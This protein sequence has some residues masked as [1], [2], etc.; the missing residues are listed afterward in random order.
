ML[1]IMRVSKMALARETHLV[2]TI[3]V[4]DETINAGT[5]KT[6]K[7]LVVKD[8]EEIMLEMRNGASTSLDVLVFTSSDKK[9]YDTVPYI[10]WN[11]GANSQLTRGITKGMKYLSVKADNKDTVNNSA[12]TIKL[13]IQYAIIK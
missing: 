5:S 10:S 9:N 13:I 8:A 11:L 12:V 6:V 7:D 4:I 3:T 1:L 2:E